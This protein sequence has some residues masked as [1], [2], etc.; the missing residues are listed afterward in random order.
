M[1]DK[2]V[3]PEPMPTPLENEVLAILIEECSE[4][5][6][7]ATKMQR[8]GINEVQPG[9]ELTNAERLS[10]E[11]GDLLE[12]IRLAGSVKIVHRLRLPAAQDR[13]AAK[14]EQFMQHNS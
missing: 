11:V 2:F 5:I 1:P 12:T 13:K 9:Q 8:F 3:T 6:Q 4:V 14:L 7:R 10:D